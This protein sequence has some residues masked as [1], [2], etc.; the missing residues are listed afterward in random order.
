MLDYHVH[1]RYCRHATGEVEDYVKAALSLGL[2][3]IGFADHFPMFYLPE[4][5]YDDYS[6][7]FEELPAYVAE[8]GRVRG[9]FS[10]RIGVKVG[11]EVDYQRGKETTI[12]R[13]VS[14]QE[15]DYLIGVIHLVDG[16]VIDDTRNVDKF[17]E[18]E[19]DKLYRK[20]F[21]ELEALIKSGIFDIVGHIDVIKRFN[22]IP[23]G[24]VEQYVL[25]CLDL[26]AEK[27]LC[28]E[29]NTSGLDRPVCDTYP[30][31]NLLEAMRC[32]GIPITLGSDAH[33]P[34]EVGRHFG[35]VLVELKKSG[36]LE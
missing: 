24:G 10:D 14:T 26:I 3:E 35:R 28:V 29:L 7:D 30:G 13:A 17:R 27:G 33:D 22:F 2:D 5:P 8:V 31:L 11:V 1:T 23:E 19:L 34:A 16:W 12:K 21:D 6:M 25:P 20:Y 4:L 15:F 32:R 36:Y 18:Y 9:M